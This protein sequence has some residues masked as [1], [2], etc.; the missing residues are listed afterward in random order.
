MRN[1][2]RKLRLFVFVILLSI[3]NLHTK[4][5]FHQNHAENETAKQKRKPQNRPSSQ[6]PYHRL[7]KSSNPHLQP[8]K[9]SMDLVLSESP[10]HMT[11]APFYW[12]RPFPFVC[13][14]LKRQNRGPFCPKGTPFSPFLPCPPASHIENSSAVST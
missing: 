10:A 3:S 12:K 9:S 5:S 13:Y 7:P 8:L 4:W 14:G 1:A 2:S 6:F 11:S